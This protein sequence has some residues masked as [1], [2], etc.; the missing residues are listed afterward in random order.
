MLKKFLVTFL[1]LLLSNCS[2]PGTA[3]LGPIFTGAKT[4]SVYQA[5]LSYGS[6]K[7]IRNLN[8]SDVFNEVNLI[9]IGNDNIITEIPQFDKNPDVLISYKVDQ[10]VFSDVIE[11]EPLP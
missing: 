7:I 11:P 4:G 3:L 2:A 5:S 10:V 6:G 1:F 8:F 9:N